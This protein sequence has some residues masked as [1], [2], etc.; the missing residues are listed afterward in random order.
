[1]SH[2][3]EDKVTLTAD[4]A[5]G[6]KLGDAETELHQRNPIE[7]STATT[8]EDGSSST[9]EGKHTYTE[10]ASNAAGQATAVAAGVKDSVFSMFGGGAKKEKKADVEEE[11]GA[12]TS[13]SAKATKEAEAE[14]GEDD[15]V[16]LSCCFGVEEGRIRSSDAVWFPYV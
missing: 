1:M 7:S 16:G 3:T 5:G 15:E 11:E 6:A 14:K 10:M 2:P 13:G 8:T 9:T 12:E 4:N